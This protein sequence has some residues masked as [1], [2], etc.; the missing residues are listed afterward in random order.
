MEMN[1]PT[2][3]LKNK[4][5]TDED[6]DKVFKNEYQDELSTEECV[7]DALKKYQDENLNK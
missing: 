7:I 3:S 5:K 1:K 2:Q 6:C 4:L